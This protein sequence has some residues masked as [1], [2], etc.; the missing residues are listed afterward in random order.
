MPTSGRRAVER[1]QAR[2]RT[3]RGTTS[4][5]RTPAPTRTRARHGVDGDLAQLAHVDEDR[6]LER[7]E[8]PGV[9]AGRL[10]RDAQAVLGGV[11]DD[12]GHVGLVAGEDDRGGPQVDARLK[13]CRAASQSGSDG[14]TTRPAHLRG[15]VGR[16]EWW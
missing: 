14:C 10:R 15:E 13:P 5:Q 2:A 3:A 7:A 16:R 8:R 4:P 6:V 11:R 12:G 1:R 9:V